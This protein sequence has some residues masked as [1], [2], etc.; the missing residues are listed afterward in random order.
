MDDRDLSRFYKS[1]SVHILSSLCRD[2]RDYFSFNLSNSCKLDI[3]ISNFEFT[4]IFLDVCENLIKNGKYT[5]YCTVE[6]KGDKLLIKF[7]S[8]A[9][10]QKKINFVFPTTLISNHKR[11]KVIR[12]LEKINS[13][14]LFRDGM[15]G[16]KFRTDMEELLVKKLCKLGNPYLFDENWSS[17]YTDY[18]YVYKIIR[19]RIEQRKLVDY[20]LEKFNEYLKIEYKIVGNDAVVFKGIKSDTLNALLIDLKQCN[21]TVSEIHKALYSHE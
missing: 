10:S 7:T 4:H 2:Y 14:Q 1:Y 18:Y 17:Y 15:K 16:I 20:V 21:K 12:V 5:V 9:I 6:N 3:D 19:K 11:K 13:D 8:A